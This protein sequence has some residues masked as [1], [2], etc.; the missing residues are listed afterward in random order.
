MT[1]FSRLALVIQGKIKP[2]NWI[3]RAF[4]T[5]INALK[6]PAVG[7]SDKGKYLKTNSETGAL[8]WASGGG[9]GANPYTSTPAPLGV[10]SA[11]ESDNYARGDHVHAMPSA[12]DVGASPA[13]TEVTVSTAG[14][15][16]QALDAGKIYHFTGAL[17]SLTITLNAAGTG[18][19]PH[20]HFDF[21]CGS[22]APTVTI[23]NTVTMP[24][25]NSFDANK[26]YEVDILNNYGAVIEWATS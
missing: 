3:E 12:S 21:D 13:V 22:T 26:H 7:A 9:G 19:V 23:P 2:C 4:L 8:E 20:Y 24:S 18:V 15:V 10:A 1:T 14:A 5:V 11:G 17:T 6:L 25:G 16:T